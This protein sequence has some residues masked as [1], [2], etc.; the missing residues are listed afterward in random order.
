MGGMGKAGI[1]KPAKFKKKYIKIKTNVKKTTLGLNLQGLQ[2]PAEI[3]NAAYNVLPDAS[4]LNQ[5]Q[6]E[7]V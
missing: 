1:Y 7:L 5:S 3:L 2:V 4:I 6:M